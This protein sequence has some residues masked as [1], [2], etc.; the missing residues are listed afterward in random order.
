[1]LDCLFHF[2][3]DSINFHVLISIA[4][5]SQPVSDSFQVAACVPRELVFGFPQ[6]P[7]RIPNVNQLEHLARARL[8]AQHHQTPRPN[9]FGVAD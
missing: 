6:F 8:T 7:Q 2:P 9:L 1:L 4:S 5:R 3:N